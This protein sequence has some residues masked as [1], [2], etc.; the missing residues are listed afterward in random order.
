MAM[1]RE[2][3]AFVI[4]GPVLDFGRTCVARWRATP[5]PGEPGVK[6]LLAR[7]AIG[8]AVAGLVYTPQALSYMVLNGY[9]GPSRLVARKMTWWSPH[10][11]EVL[12]SP[13]HGLFFWTPL[14]LLATVGLVALAARG[15]RSPFRDEAAWITVCLLTI[16]VAQIYVAGSVESWTVA[17]AFGQRR[18]VAV[19]PILVFGL[20]A[21]WHVARMGTQRG[22]V[23]I[24]AAL[25]IW[26]N[27][28]LIAQFGAGLMDRQ[29][30][31][32]VRS[33]YMNFVELPRRLPEL[34][35][36]YFF[37]RQSFYRTP[38]A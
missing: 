24:L 27:L 2:Q 17:G 14:A 34:T 26:W 6:P 21:L 35:A 18:F 38:G 36:R 33:A 15:A 4:A 20:A 10:F 19:T 16:F 7:A 8:C 9:V 30:L 25:C 29:R 32:P 3:D 13:S 5:S 28:G 23:T 31:E 37:E 1:V 11:A 22:V 12:F